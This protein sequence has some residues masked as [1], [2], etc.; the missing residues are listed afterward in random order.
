[1][2]AGFSLQEVLIGAVIM[3]LMWAA[4]LGSQLAATQL[5]GESVSRSMLE[6]K[7]IFATKDLAFDLRWA[8]GSSLLITEEN[9]AD[10]VDLRTAVDY[11]EGE[12]VWSTPVSY[13]VEAAVRDTNGNGVLDD[14]RLVRIQDG[15][16]RVLCDN[17]ASAGFTAERA[18]DDLALA[19]LL[20]K[21]HRGRW[22]TATANTTT[23]IR[24]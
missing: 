3:L 4:C 7:A 19:V 1:M 23:S 5:L 18:G 16:T 6:E 15:V 22:L 24:N 12:P 9:D 20:Q 13:R 8:E 17:V 21:M 10:R 14:R 11:A 2:N